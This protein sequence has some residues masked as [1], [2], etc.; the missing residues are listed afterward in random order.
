MI[1]F[2]VNLAKQSYGRTGPAGPSPNGENHVRSLADA[3]QRIARTMTPMVIA[4]VG[5]QTTTDIGGQIRPR[6]AADAAPVINEDTAPESSW[7]GRKIADPAFTVG[8]ALMKAAQEKPVNLGNARAESDTPRIPGAPRGLEDVG[9]DL[10]GDEARARAGDVRAQ[11]ALIQ[12]AM[13]P[14]VI[15]TRY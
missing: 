3:T 8:T 9:G 10:F 7:V 11:Q 15:T 1:N 5:F 6:A 13:K 12:R 4:G 14:A 2:G